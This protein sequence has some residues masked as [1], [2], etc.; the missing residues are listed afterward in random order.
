[1]LLDRLHLG[2]LHGERPAIVSAGAHGVLGAIFRVEQV[3]D[4]ANFIRGCALNLNDLGLLGIG[5]KHRAGRK[6]TLLQIGLDAGDGV[7]GL[8]TDSFIHHDL[9]HQVD[10]TF[11][12][13]TEVDAVGQ[14]GL[15]GG[16]T[17]ALRQAEDAVDEDEED[18]KDEEGFTHG[19][20][21]RLT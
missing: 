15:P 7:V 8:C 14:R 3:A 18:G 19:R 21:N 20:A 11:E 10:T 6:A 9:Q 1:M 12:V 2:L 5:L 17:N 4:V 13:K 16:G